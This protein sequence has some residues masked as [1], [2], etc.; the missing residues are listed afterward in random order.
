MDSISKK[1]GSTHFVQLHRPSP[2]SFP[3]R[4]TKTLLTAIGLYCVVSTPRLQGFPRQQPNL[5]NSQL[6]ICRTC[7]PISRDRMPPATELRRSRR[8][9]EMGDKTAFH[10]LTLPV[11]IRLMI[12][13]LILVMRD[14]HAFKRDEPHSIFI[15]DMKPGMYEWNKRR[16]PKWPRFDTVAR[17][18]VYQPICFP[19]TFGPLDHSLPTPM[20]TY[21]MR[22]EV[23]TRNS[24]LRSL[25][26]GLGILGVNRQICN[27]AA[28]ILYGG[29]TWVFKSMDAVIPFLK[30]RK[31]H[32]LHF[33]HLQFELV[34][35]GY[36]SRREVAETHQ[37]WIRVFHQ[38]A[39]SPS[40]KIKHLTLDVCKPVYTPLS[41]HSTT[42]APSSGEIR[43]LDLDHLD[44][45]PMD[46]MHSLSDIQSLDSLK[47]QLFISDPILIVRGPEFADAIAAIW[48]RNHPRLFDMAKR[49]TLS[50]I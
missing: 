22:K 39:N 25:A 24:G 7:H 47:I 8:L 16:R 1:S 23:S 9:W 21:T 44:K 40:F 2:L 19:P 14:K 45:Q 27:E 32:W 38:I 29:N 3:R 26:E 48:K 50:L 49:T 30:D 18:T 4:G 11:E 31:E 20:V 37:Q 12:Y 41:Q 5:I 17:R 28:P 43:G 10:F 46:W 13:R 35:H 6:S 36:P 33:R 15:S 34:Q 42:W